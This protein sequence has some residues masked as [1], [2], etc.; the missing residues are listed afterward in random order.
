MGFPDCTP[1]PIAVIVT[2]V[3]M[4]GFADR[5]QIDSLFI[6]K[7]LVSSVVSIFGLSLQATTALVTRV[8]MNLREFAS[9][10]GIGIPDIPF[11]LKAELFFEFGEVVVKYKTSDSF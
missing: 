2:K 3:I 8:G 1:D 9:V 5:Q 6:I 7:P 11:R 10:V 4:T